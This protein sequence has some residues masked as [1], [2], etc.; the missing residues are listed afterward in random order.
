LPPDLLRQAPVASVFHT[1]KEP[2]RFAAP[3][4]TMSLHTL[5]LGAASARANRFSTRRSGLFVRLVIVLRLWWKRSSHP[6]NVSAHLRADIGLSIEPEVPNWY[7]GPILPQVAEPR[8]R[9]NT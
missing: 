7:D 4:I 6:P 3:E 8:N 9:S 1:S 5:P 2:V